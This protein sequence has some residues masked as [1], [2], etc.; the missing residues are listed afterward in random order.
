[1]KRRFV[2]IEGE[3]VEVGRDYSQEPRSEYHIM[4]DI[5]PYMSMITGEQIT[6]RSHHR[7][8]LK[9]H[10]YIEVGNDSSLYRKPQ[11][12]KSPPG[13]KETV[14]RVVNEFE[15]KQRRH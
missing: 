11:P 6:S 8:H 1:M 2:Q 5:E 4:G 3:L 7:A 12:I 10:G 9:Q 13:L 14:I 15:E